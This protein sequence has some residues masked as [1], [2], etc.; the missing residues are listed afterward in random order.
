MFPPV[1]P[2][3][4]LPVR[5]SIKAFTL[6]EIIVVLFFMI[7]AAA[8]FIPRFSSF[9]Q[10][11]QARDTARNIAAL[12]REARELAI[13]HQRPI[14]LTT[15]AVAHSV[16][17]HYDDTLLPQPD[18]ESG[19]ALAVGGST[20]GSP[21]RPPLFYPERILVEMQQDQSAAFSSDGLTFT[22]DGRAPDADLLVVYGQ[23]RAL[24]VSVR[25]QAT[26]VRID[27]AD[28]PELNDMRAM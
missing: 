5:Q 26:R 2:S 6:I 7:A 24:R 23:E 10:A 12:I 3:P 21:P 11:G 20:S 16:E 17:L 1:S 19:Y 28:T 27:S 14:T 15:N 9:Q 13:E 4:R 22:P 25:R 18:S 8:M